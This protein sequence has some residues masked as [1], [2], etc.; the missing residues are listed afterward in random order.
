MSWVPVSENEHAQFAGATY[1][2]Q[3][4]APELVTKDTERVAACIKAGLQSQGYAVG[5]PVTPEAALTADE[6]KIVEATLTELNAL[7]SA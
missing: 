4:L 1:A 5:D 2:A 3:V 7:S 6:R